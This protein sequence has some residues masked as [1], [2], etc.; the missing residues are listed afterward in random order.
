MAG[1]IQHVF[2]R[3]VGKRAIF[4]DD[5][6]RWTFL[7]MLA[8][9]IES[10]GWVVLGYCLMD[11]HFHLIVQTREPNL[12]W[13]MQRLLSPYVQAFHARHGGEGH[14]FERRFNS[15]RIKDDRQLKTV[16]R[17]VARN[18]VEAGMCSA[19]EEHAWSSHRHLVANTADPLVD[20][21]A[22]LGHFGANGGDPLATYAEIVAGA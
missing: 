22:L 15:V 16:V 9:V 19:P 3:G 7:R 18:P 20:R 2:S 17:Y 4:I 12:G 10:A 11:N 14:H 6:D 1:A 21:E 8:R 13:G 5:E